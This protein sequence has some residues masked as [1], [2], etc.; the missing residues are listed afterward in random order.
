MPPFQEML[1]TMMV[2]GNELIETLGT[3]GQTG[4]MV[5]AQGFAGM[6]L[7][8]MEKSFSGWTI[9]QEAGSFLEDCVVQPLSD[10]SMGDAGLDIDVLIGG[11]QAQRTS[12]GHVSPPAMV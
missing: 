8:I 7:Y 10:S 11:G 4:A 6:G 5:A 9:F 2:S 1:H 3:V 12:W